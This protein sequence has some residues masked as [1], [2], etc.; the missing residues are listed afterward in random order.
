M[1]HKDVSRTTIDFAR[2]LANFWQQSKDQIMLKFPVVTFG[3]LV[4]MTLATLSSPTQAHEFWIS[5]E[6]YQVATGDPLLANIRVGETF[7]GGALS[8]IDRNTARFEVLL[9]GQTFEHGSTLGDRPA[10][11]RSIPGDGLAVVVHE[12]TDS[13]LTYRDWQKFVNFVEHKDFAG[14]LER[15][16]ERGLPE[17]GFVETYRR[18]AK[19]LIAIADGEGR[20]LNVGLDTEIIALA[21]PYTDDLNAGL[22]VK[23]LLYGMP[24]ADT[25]VEVFARG[26]DGMTETQLYRTN[27]DGVAVLNVTP[28]TEYQV[29]SVV[30]EERSGSEEGA[31]VWHTM[32]AN[33]TF[34]VPAAPTTN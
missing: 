14:A 6:R 9:G 28:G 29:D 1:T 19:S 26:D 7:K 8:Y 15:H 12:T 11:S 4:T 16:V 13:R 31:A 32:W 20:D 30:L 27:Q 17:T 10:L 22:P 24:R 2:R 21:N 23:V 3:A 34:K 5:P 25:Q 33:L 18:Y